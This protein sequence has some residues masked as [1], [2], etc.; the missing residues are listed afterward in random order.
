MLRKFSPVVLRRQA[1]SSSHQLGSFLSK[2]NGHFCHFQKAPLSL[3]IVPRSQSHVNQSL[4]ASVNA[5]MS[6]IQQQQRQRKPANNDTP[7]PPPPTLPPAL[8]SVVRSA[9][10]GRPPP[11]AMIKH[12]RSL[13]AAEVGPVVDLA[14]AQRRLE[15]VLFL[16][17]CMGPGVQVRASATRSKSPRD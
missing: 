9:P 12:I 16:I 4:N 11:L 7:A 2:Y 1:S 15:A 3:S 14:V 5:F 17:D 13:T 10:N 6:L 8:E